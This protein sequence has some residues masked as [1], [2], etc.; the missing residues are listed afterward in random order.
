[1]PYIN[2]TTTAKITK[3]KEEELVREFGKAIELIPGK[4]EEWLMLNFTDS[5]RMAFR[6]TDEGGAA[7]LEVEIFGSA[8]AESKASLTEELCKI[9]TR[10]LGIKGERVYVKYR[11]C[12]CWGYNGFNF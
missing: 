10:V 6:G 8:D 11:E 5:A 12:D 2:T 4:S 7:M 9:I 1:M 3:E